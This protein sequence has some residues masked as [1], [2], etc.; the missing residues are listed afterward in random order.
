[1]LDAELAQ[2]KND[3]AGN[4]NQVKS[5]VDR[6]E[7]TGITD[8][9]LFDPIAERLK[10]NYLDAAPASM[11]LNSWLVK[12]LGLSGQ[13][14]YQ[15]LFA[16]IMQEIQLK[17]LYNHTTKAA[18]RQP[19]FQRWNAII[20]ANN[21][22]AKTQDELNRVRL[23]NMLMSNETVLQ[24]AATEIIHSKYSAD[25]PLLQ[26][27]HSVLSASY[28]QEDKVPALNWMCRT[29]GESGIEEFKPTLQTIADDPL[30]HKKVRAYAK[31]YLIAK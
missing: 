18:K 1:M 7:W 4:V 23:H 31:K 15:A 13:E 5:A 17:Q 11:E 26:K 16:Q 27:I 30:A 22:E 24:G 21:S 10:S 20:A 8:V 19:E 9:T 12:P 3:F 25:L 29:L 2:F 6:L 28:R 14:K